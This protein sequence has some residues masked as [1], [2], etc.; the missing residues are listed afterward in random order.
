MKNLIIFFALLFSGFQAYA[1][2]QKIKLSIDGGFF[3]QDL[4]NVRWEMYY[5]YSDKFIKYIAQDSG[6]VS[7]LNF[8][9]KFTDSGILKYEEKWVVPHKVFKK[10]SIN[11]LTIFCT[12]TFLLPPGQYKV[13]V[14][15]FDVNNKD[16]KIKNEFEI[17][18][19]KFKKDRIEISSIQL[20]QLIINADSSKF[21]Y[22][23]MFKKFNLYVIP[24][25]SLEIEGTNSRLITYSEIYNANQISPEGIKIRY[26]IYDGANRELYKLETFRKSNADIMPEGANILLSKVPTGVYYLKQTVIYPSDKPTDSVSIIKKF[27]LINPEKGPVNTNYFTENEQFSTSSF[28]SFDD[29]RV[30]E[31]IRKASVIADDNEKEQMKRLGTKEAKQRYLFVFWRMK[32]PD[33]T[34]AVNKRYEDF[35]R[36]IQYANMY[37]KTS[38]K[39]GWDTDRGKVMLKYGFPT[40]RKEHDALAGNNAYE[41]WFFENVQGGSYFYFVDRSSLNNFILYHST[42]KGEPYNPEWY[43]DYVPSTSL[44]GQT[45][46]TNWFNDDDIRR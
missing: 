7:E 5:S 44:K 41:E 34:A 26:N 2:E 36:A 22:D 29:S 1:Q 21:K 31:E 9:I 38:F 45:R 37:F 12:K 27:F 23:E 18:A 42:V 15:A 40:E 33:T 32:D 4:N 3:F 13:E 39:Q 43:N 6:F 19:S 14:N 10:E 35:N 16:V 24:N 30:D 8:D 20:A 25:P 46:E 28:A 17:I 11:D